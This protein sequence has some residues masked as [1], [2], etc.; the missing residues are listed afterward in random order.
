MAMAPVFYSESESF[1]RL[2]NHL[3]VLSI[4]IS[5]DSSKAEE[6]AEKQLKENGFCDKGNAE[7]SK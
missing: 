6:N 2:K 5:K 4:Y 3:Q 1:K 7:L